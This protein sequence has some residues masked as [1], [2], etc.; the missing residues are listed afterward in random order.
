VTVA[1]A[2][3]PSPDLSSTEQRP[4]E[5]GWNLTVAAMGMVA[6]VLLL[7]LN[8][9]A[10]F[11]NDEWAFVGP[12][13][14]SLLAPNNE[15]WSAVP[16]VTYS[17]LY[18]VFR[19]RTYTPYLLLVLLA[20]LAACY[21][22]WRLMRRAGVDIAPAFG[23]AM[24][25]MFL[26][27][28]SN[29]LDWAWEISYVLPVALGLGWLLLLDR[30]RLGRAAWLGGPVLGC[31]VVAS[32]GVGLA[33]LFAVAL[34]ALLRHGWRTCVVQVGV[35]T[36]VFVAWYLSNRT[37]VARDAFQVADLPA[38]GQFV[39][40]GY[41]YSFADSLDFGQPAIAFVGGMLAFLGVALWAL[42][43][44]RTGWRE[45]AIPVAMFVS[46][47][48]LF[49]L[50]G[51]ARVHEHGPEYANQQRYIYNATLVALP[52]VGLALTALGRRHGVGRVL[53]PLVV[54]FS[55][56]VNAVQLQADLLAS[57]G[58][59]ELVKNSLAA[60]LRLDPGAALPGVRIEPRHDLVLTLPMARA[61]AADG[62]FGPLPEPSTDTQL[63]VRA[64][65]G[66]AMTYETVP[67]SDGAPVIAILPADRGVVRAVGE[68]GCVEAPFRGVDTRVRVRFRAADGR[69]SV[70]GSGDAPI[71]LALLSDA[72]DSLQG[73]AE[74]PLRNRPGT[75]TVIHEALPDQVAEILFAGTADGTICGV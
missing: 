20:H 47:G 15:H 60:A 57:G 33:V 44:Y 50:A 28:G 42:Y 53:V 58:D 21:M 5:R 74:V 75:W 24:V 72:G 36:A 37:S 59:R 9:A 65:L 32:S 18:A 73:R 54:G 41:I 2:T 34:A 4:S 1:A 16:A 52:L 68:G 10:W 45:K 46:V 62:A 48:V 49:L 63:R 51:L 38:L 70:L 26:G 61:L 22:L 66:V 8:Q 11:S 27:A 17:A 71:T 12:G 67:A 64:N 7:Y 14:H 55:L 56:A 31:L 3:T 40:S 30:D 23:L 19:L 69:F 6:L 35:P 43:A 25:A 13:G 39:M 29:N